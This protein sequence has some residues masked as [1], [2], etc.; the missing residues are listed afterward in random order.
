M[1]S[2]KRGDMMNIANVS[3]SIGMDFDSNEIRIVQGKASKKGIIINKHFSIKIPREVY[4]DGVIKDMEQL[5]YIVK[6]GLDANGVSSGNVHAVINS[7]IIIIRE[8]GF[9]KVDKEDIDNLI[10]YQLGDFVPIHPEDYVVK[11]INL[12]SF[13]DDGVEKLNML[14]IGVPKDVVEDHFNLIKGLGLKPV[15]MDY[16]GNAI[17]KLLSY[18][19]E[20]NNQIV[21][22]KTLGLLDLSYESTT[23]TVVKDELIEVSRLIEGGIYEVIDIFKE[24]FSFSEEQ[25]LDWFKKI[26][27]MGGLVEVHDDPKVEELK[28]SIKE[29]A[30]KIEMVVRY[31]H[32]REIENNIDLFVLHGPLATVNGMEKF[33]SDLFNIPCISLQSVEKLKFEGDLSKYGNAIGGLIRV[34][35]V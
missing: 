19:E 20:I 7:S 5:S 1:S 3:K 34:N 32:T 29:I 8:V 33:F 16:K 25:T 21:K 11:Y 35:G 9:P 22:G 6:D 15:V 26:A 2:F 27:D 12:G 23:F 30:A 10:E 31:Y 4:Q 28:S 13:M 18:G 14:I 17:S 24:K